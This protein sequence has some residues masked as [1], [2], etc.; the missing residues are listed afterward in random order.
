MKT[1]NLIT[2]A[3][4]S[5][6]FFS[7]AYSAGEPALQGIPDISIYE[8]SP[9]MQKAVNLANYA[10]DD[11]GA[12]G[13]SYEIARQTNTNLMDCFMEDSHYISCK[14]PKEDSTGMTSI[15]ARVTNSKGLSSEDTFNIVVSEKTEPK[16]TSISLERESLTLAPGSSS[17]IMFEATNNTGDK[18]CYRLTVSMPDDD[19]T[20]ISARPAEEEFCIEDKQTASFS[21]IIQAH[22]S[23]RAALYSPALKLKA[24]GGSTMSKTISVNVSNTSSPIGIDRASDYFVCIK[25]YSQ[26][27][28]ATIENNTGS[29]QELMLSADNATLLPEF[30]YRTVS[31]GQG[32]DREIGITIHTTHE[33][34]TGEYTIT[35]RAENSTHKV[36]REMQINLIEC[37]DDIMSLEVTP[38]QR[39]ISKGEEK[40]FT[41]TV[42]NKSD[43]EQEIFISSEGDIENKVQYSS[44]TLKANAQKKIDLDVRAAESDKKGEHTIKVYA[45]N[46][47]ESEEKKIKVT[48]AS[49]HNIELEIPEN[50]YASNSI[51]AEKS[52]IYEIIVHN[53]GDYDEDVKVSVASQAGI[54]AKLSD[55][56][57]EMKNNSSR[58]IYLAVST[59]LETPAGDYKIPITAKTKKDGAEQDL[60]VRITKAEPKTALELTSYPAQIE[61]TQGN[62]SEISFTIRNNSASEARNITISLH[63]NGKQFVMQP[64]AIERLGGMESATFKAK[65]VPS[66]ELEEGVYPAKIEIRAKDFTKALE[67]KIKVSK[68]SKPE[69]K[70]VPATG[71]FGLSGGSLILGGIMLL[72]ILALAGIGANSIIEGKPNSA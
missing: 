11:A 45:W 9:Q 37:D 40:T 17:A 14:A 61:A 34:A 32:Q 10:A 25:P 31:V 49:E 13:L 68:A 36:Q 22:E 44:I 47:K 62:E 57:F 58:K 63:G 7:A 46:S 4:F 72:A 55:D 18:E 24:D 56:S 52:G 51:S 16:E 50:S 8:N 15:T 38:E 65:I 12:S 35:A 71:L 2:T 3:F 54:N 48:V 28:E 66:K 27:I 67:I 59:E 6:I 42:V 21:I 20:E 33:T 64:I 41:I 29:S 43:E 23:A 30:D 69:E 1:A 70:P 5:I 19:R 60:K 53:Y 39:S 26:K